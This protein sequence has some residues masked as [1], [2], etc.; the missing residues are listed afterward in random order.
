MSRGLDSLS[1]LE[2]RAAEDFAARVRRDLGDCVLDIRVFG[3]RARGEARE[4][5]DLDI[6]VLLEEADGSIRRTVS[7]LATDLLLEED[8][9]LVISPRVMSRDQH[10]QLV[11]LERLLPAEIERDGIPL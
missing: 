10:T 11:A 2:R 5:S 8:L 1:P 9:P 6:W 3:S 7:D 4:D